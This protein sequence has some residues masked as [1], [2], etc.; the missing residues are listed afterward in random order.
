MKIL[1]VLPLL[2]LLALASMP[3]NAQLFGTITDAPAHAL[4]AGFGCDGNRQCSAD[5]G[6]AEKIGGATYSYSAVEF[7]PNIVV[8]PNGTRTLGVKTVTTTGAQ[9]L[10]YQQGRVSLLVGVAPGAAL[11]TGNS[12]SFNFAMT[13]HATIAF[14]LNSALRSGPGTSN[15][16]L[17]ITPYFTQIAGVPNGNTIAVRLHFIHGMN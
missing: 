12:P 2:L 5:L 9:Q 7:V 1:R 13:E 16:H 17:A 3:A 14:R 10:I 4:A 8:L 15:N 11:P 6:F